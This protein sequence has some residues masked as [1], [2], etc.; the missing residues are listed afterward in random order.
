MISIVYFASVD[1]TDLPIAGQTRSTIGE[2][3]Q[4]PFQEALDALAGLIFVTGGELCA[5]KSWCYIIDFKWTVKKWE[6]RNKDDIH[7]DY[8]LFDKNKRKEVL[9]RL[10]V[11]EALETLGVYLSPDGNDR[12]QREKLRK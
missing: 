6:Y 7:G 8:Y 11:S 9:K 10:D 3:L 5:Q 12:V 4:V 2:E 1:D